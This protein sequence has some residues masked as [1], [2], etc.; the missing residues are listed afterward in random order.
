MAT[1]DEADAG[2]KTGMGRGHGDD[3]SCQAIS[4]VHSTPYIQ[5]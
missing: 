3:D 2:K 4:P 1:D 5:S